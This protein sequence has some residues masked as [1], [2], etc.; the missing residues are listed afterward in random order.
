MNVI[1]CNGCN[2]SSASAQNMEAFWMRLFDLEKLDWCIEWGSWKAL[3][4]CWMQKYTAVSENWIECQQWLIFTYSMLEVYNRLEVL[5]AAV[6]IGINECW[7]KKF[8]L[9]LTSGKI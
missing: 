6:N 7:K 2:F 4:L 3:L 9:L 8:Q 1:N 5:S